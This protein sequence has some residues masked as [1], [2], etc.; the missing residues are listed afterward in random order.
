MRFGATETKSIFANYSQLFF[1]PNLSFPSVFVFFN[2]HDFVSTYLAIFQ[3]TNFVPCHFHSLPFKKTFDYLK[4]FL[5]FFKRVVSL[6]CVYLFFTNFFCPKARHFCA[7]KQKKTKQKQ[8]NI[9]IS[10]F[11]AYLQ[12]FVTFFFIFYDNFLVIAIF[13]IN[14]NNILCIRK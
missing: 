7:P 6:I 11:S 13:F 12:S 4:L 1:L 10:R 8:N 5:S 2:S 3:S 9:K 14:A